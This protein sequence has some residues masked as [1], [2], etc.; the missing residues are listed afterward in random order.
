MVDGITPAA[1]GGIPNTNPA[2]NT[3]RII[4][5]DLRLSKPAGD[6][7]SF[8]GGEAVSNSQALQIVTERAFEKLRSVV[9]E[10]RAELGIPEGEELDTSPEATANRIADFA[11]GFFDNYAE[12]NSLADDAEGRQQ[13][14]DFIGAAVQQGIDEARG[15]LT[16][17]QALNPE[18][19]GNIEQ[20]SSIIQNRFAD[21]VENGI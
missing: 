4:P 7:V 12:N 21:F 1:G 3:R 19:D 14:V 10:A 9:A 20:T 2:E 5:T 11:L 6:S 15:I 8:G 16:S 13:F 17:L 18:V